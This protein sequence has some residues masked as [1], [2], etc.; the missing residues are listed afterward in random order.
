MNSNK[1]Y[2]NF[3]FII[4]MFFKK[5][6]FLRVVLQE[7]NSH[8]PG[9]KIEPKWLCFFQPLTLRIMDIEPHTPLKMVPI[10][11]FSIFVVLESKT[12]M[13]KYH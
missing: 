11:N 6:M 5:Q 2:V 9:F 4:F 8:V 12:L 3:L 13:P 7:Y 1:I 10:L